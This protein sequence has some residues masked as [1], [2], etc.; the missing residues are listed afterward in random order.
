MAYVGL[1]GS[2][3][4]EWRKG[5]VVAR[6]PV[7]LGHEIVGRVAIAANDGSGPSSGTSVVVDVVTG[8]GHCFHCLH[9]EEGRCRD[10][11]VTGQHQ[12]GGLATHVRTRASRLL[13]VPDSSSLRNAALAEPLAVALRA[14]RRSQLTPGATVV[15]IGGGTVGLLTARVARAAGAG[16]VVVIEPR[17]DRHRH[18]QASDA[19]PLWR[20]DTEEMRTVIAELVGG[21][22]ADLV[23][24]SAGR[25]DTP[26]LAVSFARA[27]GTV[28]LLGVV[29][30]AQPIDVLQV[31]LA[32]KTVMGSAAHMWDDDVRVAVD[33]IARKRIHV[34]DLIT[35]EVEL[36]TVESGFA[37]LDSD[38]GVLKLLVKVAGG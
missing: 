10:L 13:P 28:M 19:V 7:V 25:S 24:E 36:E 18:I 32:E 3:L 27:G 30:D 37:L 9:H 17:T 38:A 8:C 20:D 2:D 5:P 21:E 4:E 26:A 22:G 12:D 33:F 14:I 35:H 23:V 1:C 6:P 11:V 31:V 15:I 16:T 29:E 34:E